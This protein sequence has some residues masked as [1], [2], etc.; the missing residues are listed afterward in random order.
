M[1][2]RTNIMLFRPFEESRLEKW[3]PPYLVQP[4]L[5][6]ERCRA[7][8]DPVN[9]WAL[10]SSE[11]N[12]FIS[13]PHIVHELNMSSI[14][15]DIELDGELYCHGKDFSEIC[16]IVSRTVNLHPDFKSICFHIFDIVGPEPQ[17]ERIANYCNKTLPFHLR[18]VTTRPAYNFDE[19]MDSYKSYLDEGYEGMVVRHFSAP[20]LRCGTTD[21]RTLYGMKF[22]PKKQDIYKIIGYKQM[23]DKD[24]NL[25][26]KLGALI[27]T[28]PDDN[29]EF[30]VG[31]GMNDSFRLN[32]WP[33]DDLIGLFVKVEYQHITSGKNV[34]RFPIFLTIVENEPE[35]EM[36]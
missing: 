2:N 14:P 35:I 20:Y 1:S 23:I 6:G 27:C 25:K 7:L 10:Y 15:K 17:L 34:P 13:V 29:A 36:F 24:G 21:R 8:Y 31:S 32:N 12:Q 4:K 18:K 11:N 3:A 9:G 5:D 30:G 26:E 33:A 22:K 16:S 19:V 28:G